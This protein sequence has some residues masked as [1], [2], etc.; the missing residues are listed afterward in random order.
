LLVPRVCFDEV[1]LFDE[2]LRRMEDWEWLLRFAERFNL[3]RVDE[4]LAR[5]LP[6]SHPPARSVI[7]AL[8]RIAAKHLPIAVKRGRDHERQLLAALW[9]ERAAVAYHDRQYALAAARVLRS[10]ATYPRRSRS[11]YL[12]MLSILWL[13][14]RP[15]GR[16]PIERDAQQDEL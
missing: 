5:I 3:V 11:F 1:G 16:R 12:R 8:D 4:P 7:P 14:T 2:A 10:W 9:L 15:G 6:G 13:L